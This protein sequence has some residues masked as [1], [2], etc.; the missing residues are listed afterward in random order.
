M[1]K[2]TSR[3]PIDI[4][5]YKELFSCH[6]W[7][8]SLAES[9]SSF[10]YVFIVCSIR[11]SWTGVIIGHEP[12]LLAMSLSSG[13][14]MMLLLI[15]FRSVHVNPAL[16]IAFL[17][18]GRIPLIRAMIYILIHCMS[19]IAAIAFLHSVSIKGHAGALGL[20]NPH[21]ELSVIQILV[22]E[23]VISF[24]V[25]IITFAA[26]NHS[27]Y[28]CAKKFTLQQLGQ[29]TSLFSPN[30]C[31][32]T[33]LASFN[34]RRSVAPVVPHVPSTSITLL[35]TDNL[36][37]NGQLTNNSPLSCALTMPANSRAT[38]LPHHAT[39]T[40]TTNT[41]HQQHNNNNN[42]N[43]N[44]GL[45]LAAYCNDT[46]PTMNHYEH[47]YEFDYGDNYRTTD[48]LN[49]PSSS[50]PSPQI[51][52]EEVMEEECQLQSPNGFPI[53]LTKAHAFVIGLAY[54]LASLSGV[55][56]ISVRIVT[57]DLVWQTKMKRKYLISDQ[58]SFA[59]KHV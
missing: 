23:A 32:K 1:K 41:H 28:K 29:T 37:T 49:Q 5:G 19:S 24:L 43:N 47:E 22:I 58:N 12:S 53:H 55:S 27:S 45:L 7:L 8:S 18:T 4:L 39:N 36:L 51:P 50:E 9:L 26:S 38:Q 46:T 35:N 20:D 25:T 16:T 30:S 54:F 15:T 34:S 2:L 48:Y 52:I 6:L 11:I 17:V 44:K 3:H 31:D 57:I 14:A 13:I 40:N 33:T 59:S 21:S 56:L 42:N 10:L